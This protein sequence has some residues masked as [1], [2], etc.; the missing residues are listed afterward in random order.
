MRSLMEFVKGILKLGIITVVGV[1]LIYPFYG[2]VDHF[3]GLPVPT[4]MDE[5]TSLV[6]RLMLGILVVL[7]VVAVIDLVYQRYEHFKN[8]HE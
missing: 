3:V 2:Q 7:L 5:L 1:I 8:A 6:T 4:M